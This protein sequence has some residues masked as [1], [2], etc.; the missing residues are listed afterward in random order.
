[1]QASPKK[2]P[3]TLKWIYVLLMMEGYTRRV[4]IQQEMFL[5]FVSDIIVLLGFIH[6]VIKLLIKI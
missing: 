6:A 5:L 4:A 1:M 2:Y 3:Y